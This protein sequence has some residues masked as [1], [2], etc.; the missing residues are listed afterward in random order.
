MR[1][2]SIT[3]T[4]V[5]LAACAGNS[6]TPEVSGPIETTTVSRTV[7]MKG[8]RVD[9]LTGSRVTRNPRLM[10]RMYDLTCGPAS[11]GRSIEARKATA[12][13][14]INQAASPVEPML[15]NASGRSSEARRVNAIMIPAINCR[16]FSTGQETLTEDLQ[17]TVLFGLRNGLGQ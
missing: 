13:E 16:V 6:P 10:T 1:R 15:Q 14:I 3:L 8:S 4:C 12:V 9:G 5:A 2:I 11:D 7:L 17:E